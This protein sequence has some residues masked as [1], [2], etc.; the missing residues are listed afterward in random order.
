MANRFRLKWLSQPD[1]KKYKNC[2]PAF[3]A[4]AVIAEY[5]LERACLIGGGSGRGG[6]DVGRLKK[7]APTYTG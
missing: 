4:D 6:C 1:A 7:R 2:D 5:I 3:S